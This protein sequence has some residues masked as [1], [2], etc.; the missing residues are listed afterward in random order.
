[1]FDFS[2]FEDFFK[3]EEL[4]VLVDGLGVRYN[5]LPH[6]IMQDSTIFEFNFDIAV[7]MAAKKFENKNI[8]K[9]EQ[10][11]TKIDFKKLGIKRTVIDK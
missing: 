3:K 8:K 10:Y 6:I 9:E 11:P 2:E 5:V 7:M 1:M 4:I